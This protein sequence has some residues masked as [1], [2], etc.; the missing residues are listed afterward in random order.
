MNQFSN[1]SSPDFQPPE[2]LPDSTQQWRD[3]D[4]DNQ[5]PADLSRRNTSP[6][7]K[8]MIRKVKRLYIFLIIFGLSLGIIASIGIVSLLNHLGLTNPTSNIEQIDQ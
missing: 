4:P 5:E 3:T 8:Q 2:T 6:E 7:A 1:Q